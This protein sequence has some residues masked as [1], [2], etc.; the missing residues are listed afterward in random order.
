MHSMFVL[1]IVVFVGI[2]KGYRWTQFLVL[3]TLSWTLMLLRLHM[4][5][6][7]ALGF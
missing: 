5:S 6:D 3:G 7:I 4:T 1:W 2:L